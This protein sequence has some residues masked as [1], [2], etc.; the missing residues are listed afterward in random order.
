MEIICQPWE[1]GTVKLFQALRAL[2][3]E[4]GLEGAGWSGVEGR[5]D[6]EGVGRSIEWGL[7]FFLL[8]SHKIY[9]KSDKK[10]EYF[11]KQLDYSNEIHL[12]PLSGF[13][14]QVQCIP[15]KNNEF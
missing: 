7:K 5:V 12:W 6:G 2:P 9:S 15:N 3:N 11:S 8:F 13:K 10:R 4:W 14:F 1:R